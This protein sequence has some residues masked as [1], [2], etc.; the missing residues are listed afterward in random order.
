MSVCVFS[1]LPCEG[2]LTV[3]SIS[4]PKED[5]YQTSHN[6]SDKERLVGWF[7]GWMDGRMDGYLFRANLS[8]AILTYILH[9]TASIILV[10][11]LKSSYCFLVVNKL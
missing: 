8:S 11:S 2:V 9:K 5:G 6:H 10:Q 4:G 7:F 1:V 3:L